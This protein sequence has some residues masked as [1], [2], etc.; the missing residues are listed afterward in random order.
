MQEIDIPIPKGYGVYTIESA[1]KGAR[2]LLIERNSELGGILK[3]C[4]HNGFGLAYFKEE[5]TG[6][7]YAHKFIELV[8]ADGGLN[9]GQRH[10]SISTCGLAERIYELAERKM[11]ITLLISLHAPDD[12][13]RFVAVFPRRRSSSVLGTPR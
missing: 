1:K 13:R 11:Q 6:P 3:Q 9:I 10:I 4:I 7:E 2:T 5:L 8:N 12:E